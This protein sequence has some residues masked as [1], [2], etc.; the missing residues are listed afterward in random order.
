[1]PSFSGLAEGEGFF[2]SLPLVSQPQPS[3]FARN[4]K[5]T[6]AMQTIRLLAATAVAVA[7]PLHAQEPTN[8]P[9][10]LREVVVTATKIE[11]PVEQ[12]AATVTVITREQIETRK[13]STLA[14]A[15]ESVPSLSVVRSGTPGQQTSVFTRG[16]ESNHTLLTV[17]GRRLPATLA[18]GFFYENLT[19]DN[20]DRIEVVRTPSSALYGADAIGGVINVITKNGRGLEKPEHELSF[21]GGSFNTFRESAA[22]RGAFGKFDYAVGAS[23]FNAAFPRDNNLFRLT[24]FRGSFG[25]E[26]R[27]DLYLDL[28]ASWFQSEGGS[29]GPA[30][31]PSATDFVKREVVNVS[32]GVTWDY[33]E[34]LQSKFYYTYDHQFQP[35]STFGATSRLEVDAHRVEWQNNLTP[36]EQWRITA[37]LDVTDTSADRDTG[38]VPN[39]DASVTGVGAYAQ[40]QWSPFERFNVLN[41]I[42]Y[43]TYTDYDNAVTWR[44]GVSYRL[45][46]VQTLLYGNAARSFAPPTIQDLYF[47]FGS[48]PNLVPERALSWEIGVE[49]PLLDEQLTVSAVWFQNR[50]KNFIELNPAFTPVNLPEAT[51][52]GVEAAVKWAPCQAFTARASYTYLTATDDFN[53]RRLIRRPRHQL[54]GDVTVRPLDKLTLTAGLSWNLDR[55]DA[56]FPPPA[57]A[58]ANIDYGDYLL[59]RASATYRFNDRLQVWVRGDNLTD[60]RFEHI[61]D[62]PALRAAVYG[63]LKLTF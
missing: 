2:L 48:N 23:Q 9:A 15:L 3:A 51:T 47:P 62:F 7:V 52:E 29:P 45:P 36:V 39:I 37:G 4:S 17:D 44:Q 46:R 25:Y 38:G 11:Q 14:E 21:E 27:E 8:A 57:F 10:R 40:S 34:T 12:T 1:M 56:N 19:L 41:S 16:T 26:A 5:K 49:Q 63:G 61:R 13:I 55:E 50:Y 58:R 22:S 24:S 30:T 33:S 59:A 20:V 6:R 32:P 43:D 18:G 53:N 54:S 60:D 31:F 35:S 42:R 28:K